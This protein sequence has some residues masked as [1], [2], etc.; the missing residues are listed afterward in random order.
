VSTQAQLFDGLTAKAHLVSLFV[1]G[2]NLIIQDEDKSEKIFP[3]DQFDIH[4]GHEKV[5]LTLNEISI[6]IS[7]NDYKNLQFKPR[8]FLKD[9][10]PFLKISLF[11]FS[12]LSLFFLLQKPLIHFVAQKIPDHSFEKLVAPMSD[13]LKKLHC[14]DKEQNA[15][16]AQIFT[17]LDQDLKEFKIFVIPSAEVNAFAM[18]G[19][20][21]VIHDALFKKLSSPNALA[22]ILAHE[23]AHIKE[24]HIKIGFVKNYV[25]ELLW[26]FTFGQSSV[27]GYFKEY[28][29]GFHTQEEEMSADQWAANLLIRKGLSTQG[30]IDFFE[31]RSKEEKYLQYL[32]SSHPSYPKRK[33]VFAAGIKLSGNVL[34]PEQWN[35]LQIGCSAHNIGP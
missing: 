20:M 3:M 6:I 25:W 9:A 22:G 28:V 34:N 11:L 21:I 2:K 35:K 13:R 19:N 7:L 30:V 14:L 24:E 15:I 33:D 8:S 17:S 1:S 5:T 12:L 27:P 4:I 31:G 10:K 18:P 23:I 26:L 29:K 32:S 16:L